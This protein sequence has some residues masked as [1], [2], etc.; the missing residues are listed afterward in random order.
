MVKK[1]LILDTP[2][3]VS[4]K[5]AEELIARIK[6]EENLHFDIEVKDITKHPEVLQKYQIMS[7]PGIV[8]DGKLEFTGKP[9][10]DELRKKLKSWEFK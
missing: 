1:V 2:G 8:I 5:Y 4:C 7:S 9:K 6:K 3:C 10:E